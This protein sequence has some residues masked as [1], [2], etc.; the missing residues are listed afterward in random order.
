M[1]DR[2]IFLLYL[3]LIIAAFAVVEKIDDTYYP[4]FY[5]RLY[6]PDVYIDVALYYDASQSVV[7]RLDSA[8]IFKLGQYDGLNIADHNGQE[9]IKLFRV[10]VGLIGYIHLNNGDVTNI[11][12]TNVF[13][14]HNIRTA[15]TDEDGAIVDG[16]ADI[17][18]YTCIDNVENV[19]ICL[20]EIIE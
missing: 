5:G 18:M 16:R 14:G 19:R 12:C 8:A 15:I 2:K 10:K 1:L 7:D 4:Y 6:I 20:W 3:L 13:N 9:F 11:R 17:L